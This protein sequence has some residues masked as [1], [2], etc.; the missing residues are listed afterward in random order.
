MTKGQ[1]SPIHILGK[2]LKLD[3]QLRI[4]NCRVE[5]DIVSSKNEWI[6][7]T[8]FCDSVHKNPAS[9]FS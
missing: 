5:P 3:S 1:K 8:K 2:V 7:S 9:Y 6:R 4:N